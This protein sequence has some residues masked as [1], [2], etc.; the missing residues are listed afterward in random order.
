MKKTLSPT[1]TASQVKTMLRRVFED[2]SHDGDWVL[3]L[4]DPY[5]PAKVNW[6]L[7]DRLVDKEFESQ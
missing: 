3:W 5:C 7:V 2:K 4:D 6:D 1:M